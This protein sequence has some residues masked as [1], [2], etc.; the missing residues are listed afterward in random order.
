MTLSAEQLSDMQGDLGIGADETVFTDAELARLFE[1]AEG[2]YALA[3]YYGYRQLLAQANRFHDY[4]AGMT[5]IKRS[6][7]RTHLQAS[8]DFWKSEA[9]R[10]DGVRSLGVRGVPPK[11]KDAPGAETPRGLTPGRW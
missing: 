11:R 9:K 8:L 10:A 7:M 6:Q 5:S 2:D 3:V 4:T 1:R